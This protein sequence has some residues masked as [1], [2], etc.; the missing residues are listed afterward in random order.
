MSV[1][2]QCILCKKILAL[3]EKEEDTHLLL[4]H[5]KT[6]HPQLSYKDSKISSI[7]KATLP[8]VSAEPNT[9]SHSE[10]KNRMKSLKPNRLQGMYNNSFEKYPNVNIS[11]NYEAMSEFKASDKNKHFYVTTSKFFL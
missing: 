6:Y 4:Q 10:N 8:P 1:N 11:H 3:N 5:V 2:V 7:M 9:T